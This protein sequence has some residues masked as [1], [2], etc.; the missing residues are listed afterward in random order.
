MSCIVIKDGN[1]PGIIAMDK[2]GLLIGALTNN[3]VCRSGDFYHMLVMCG[4]REFLL[5]QGYLKR[6]VY[7]R[8]GSIINGVPNKHTYVEFI[9][10][11]KFRVT[12]GEQGYHDYSAGVK[13]DPQF[14]DIL[15][16]DGMLHSS[17]RYI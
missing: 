8:T 16:P 10:E 3:F 5:K 1:G 12:F 6:D 9:A 4:L 7:E 2:E 11:R 17:K 14:K 13:V 15:G